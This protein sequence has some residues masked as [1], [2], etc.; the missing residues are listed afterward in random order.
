MDTATD[1][2]L[3]Q[4]SPTTTDERRQWA[5]L[6]AQRFRAERYRWQADAQMMTRNPR[7]K[8]EP[9]SGTPRTDGKTI[10][11]RVPIELG[12]PAK[13]DKKLCG[14]RADDLVHLCEVCAVLEDVRITM[15]HEVSH[16]VFDT[17]AVVD[18]AE[19]VRFLVDAARLESQG[20]PASKRLAKIT[21]LLDQY[22]PT[23]FI[24]GAKIISEW[25]GILVNCAED[26]RVN[27]RMM[28]A[29]KGTKKMF[30]AQTNKVFTKGILRDDGT[31]SRW[32]EQP[33]NNQALIICYCKVSGL[34]YGT[35]F[36][37][38]VT[39][40]LDDLDLDMLCHKLAT[41]RTAQSVYR[42]CIPTLER[43]RELGYCKVPDE[44]EDD[45]EP[46]PG[47]GLPMPNS[48]SEQDDSGEGSKP[49]DQPG[50]SGDSP[51]KESGEPSGQQDKSDGGSSGQ[52]DKADDDQDGYEDGSK[53]GTD[54]P[55]PEDSGAD[56]SDKDGSDSDDSGEDG[57]DAGDGGSSNSDDEGD[58]WD[59]SN[60]EARNTGDEVEPEP[61]TQEQAEAD[62]LPE[63]AEK[64][65]R[66]FG[67]H[68][69]E[70]HVSGGENS[71]ADAEE[72]ERALVQE[73]YFD[74][75]SEEIHGVTIHRNGEGPA[76]DR[77]EYFTGRVDRGPIKIPEN[78][79]SPALMRLRVLFSDNRKSKFIGDLKRGRVDGSV[80]GK[81][82]PVDD[83]RMFAKRHRPGKKDWFVVIG[84]DVSGSTGRPGLLPLIKTAAFAKAELCARMGV[85]FAV[86]AHTGEYNGGDFYNP[87]GMDLAIY[88]IK[89]AGA[90]WDVHAKERLQSIGPSSANLDGHTLEFYRKRAD[91]VQATDKVILYYTDGAMPMENYDEELEILQREIKT[92]K[93]HGIGIVGVGI[94]N[95]DPEKHGLDTV[96]L[97]RIED[98][99]KVVKELE[100]RLSRQ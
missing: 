80:L 16:I 97:D 93:Q 76:W 68:D 67:R 64:I 29:R 100:A 12:N 43:L 83:P 17:F 75:P 92:C 49:S 60:P 6:A 22:R 30:A 33:V 41:A 5:R 55:K 52:Q 31:I 50:E 24:G 86:Y 59:G 38:K 1:N 51:G 53:S 99:P 15:I 94:K 25:F 73:E 72:V 44:P 10:Y 71:Q 39:A 84:L 47:E 8:L 89:E 69:E 70:G 34:D 42:L 91:E 56:S 21:K 58:E 18:E 81:R 45:P 66:M 98:V 3:F 23:S 62:G 2:P 95:S 32:S 27:K 61:Y 40:D 7:L 88:V 82:A 90:P 46:D 28:D 65:L 77:D 14:K 57:D 20:L 19:R 63:D 26:G 13:H 74:S 37:P 54:D 79:L 4:S 78:I 87:A 9:T 96:R 11:L 36:D 85:K 48:G 35:W